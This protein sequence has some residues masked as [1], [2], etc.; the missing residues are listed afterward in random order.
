MRL[1]QG[2]PDREETLR[3]FGLALARDDFSRSDEVGAAGLV[4]KLSRQARL[5]ILPRAQD[6]ASRVELFGQFIRLYRRHLRKGFA[7]DDWALPVFAASSRPE[8]LVQRSVSRLPFELREALLLVVL[9]QFT[10]LEAARALEIP[11]TTLFERI[12]RAREMLAQDMPLAASGRLRTV[13]AKSPPHLRV[14]K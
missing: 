14:V 10:H 9:A 13:R 5:A 11:L 4:D 2:W 3:R 6:A 12:G 1:S 8:V 7:E